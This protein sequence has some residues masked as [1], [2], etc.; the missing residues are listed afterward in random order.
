[1]NEVSIFKDIIRR[2]LLEIKL[3]KI[4]NQSTQFYVIIVDK[5]VIEHGEL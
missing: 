4:N 2:V 1:M 3:L 5:H